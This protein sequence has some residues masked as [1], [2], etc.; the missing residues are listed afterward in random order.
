MFDR[1]RNI[2]LQYSM[3]VQSQVFYFAQN[4]YFKDIFLELRINYFKVGIIFATHWRLRLKWTC[5]DGTYQMIS[6]RVSPGIW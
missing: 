5:L 4:T 3:F 6:I 1:N 2:I